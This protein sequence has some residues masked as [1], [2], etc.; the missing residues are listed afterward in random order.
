ML[1]GGMSTV[2]QTD[3]IPDAPRE[4]RRGLARVADLD[5]PA[6]AVSQ[7]APM[8]TYSHTAGDHI[9]KV[10]TATM[11][12]APQREVAATLR[13]PSSTVW[14]S[15]CVGDGVRAPWCHK[16]WGFAA[17]SAISACRMV[18]CSDEW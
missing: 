10:H 17:G 5:P 8:P 3:A 4:P 12:A 1:H 11:D 9:G 14:G 2:R 6:A 13:D 16:A 7:E 15:A 18:T